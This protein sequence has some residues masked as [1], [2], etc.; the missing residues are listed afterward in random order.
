MADWTTIASLATAGGTMVLAIATFASTR[1]ANRATRVAEQSL[2]TR[3]RPLLLDSRPDD[4]DQKVGWIGQHYA[5]VGGERGVLEEL[6]GVI[7]MAASLRNVGS[8]LAL[9]HG[10]YPVTDW[11]P[12]RPVEATEIDQFRWLSRDLYI[13]PNDIGF[14]QGA[15]RDADDPDRDRMHA[16]TQEPRIFYLDILY[17]DQEGR[18]RTITRFSFTPMPE[19]RWLLAAV[20][21]WYPD[22]DDPR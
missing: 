16:I 7:Y 11:T 12:G 2:V 4:P 20:R 10:W 8:G 6:D 9:M 1:T 5:H 15:I 22:R 3:I 17:G 18:Q 21:H 19:N 14:F 13:A